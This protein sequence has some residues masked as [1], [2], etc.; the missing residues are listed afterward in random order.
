MTID[1]YKKIIGRFIGGLFLILALVG[2]ALAKPIEVKSENFVFY[3]D[4]SEKNAVALV[5]TLE[6]YRAIILTLFKANEFPEGMRVKVIGV[7]SSKKV[8]EL[9]GR[10]NASGIYISNLEGPLFIL[11]SEGGFKKGRPAS[12]I[13]LHEY[14]HHLIANYTERHYPV[15]FNEGFADYLSTFEVDKKGQ[16]SIGLPNNGRAYAL[17]RKNWFPM[18]VFVG[19][20][21]DYPFKNVSGR[22]TDDAQSLFY[23]QSWLAVHYIQ[24]T[25]EMNDKFKRYLEIVNQTSVPKDA[26]EQGFGMTPDEFGELLRAYFK[27]NKFLTSRFT[28]KDSYVKKSVVVNKISKAEL[29][30]RRA[31]AG[32]QFGSSQDVSGKIF[33]LLNKSESNPALKG[34]ATVTRAQIAFQNEEYDKALALA[35]EAV[36]LTPGD[37]KANAVLGAILVEKYDRFGGSEHLTRARN[38]LKRSLK[39]NPDYVHA[40]YLYAKTYHASRSTSPSKQAVASAESALLYYRAQRF[41][42]PALQMATVITH[43]DKPE[44]AL[45]TLKKIS[46]WGH[47]PSMRRFADRQLRLLSGQSEIEAE[48]P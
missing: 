9:T 25:P 10:K 42:G 14:T 48:T 32:R 37:Y 15:W 45:P 13:A 29:N 46:R 23:S 24:S 34:E 1:K 27:R 6:E 11:S 16:V 8:E 47:T 41:F 5:E 40:H 26:F 3:G 4:T 21:H 2:A 18:D 7:S 20:I 44:M 38:V 43:S 39:A 22:Q 33:E 17:T 28:L 12:Q 31:D 35:E 19:A 36:K 30:F